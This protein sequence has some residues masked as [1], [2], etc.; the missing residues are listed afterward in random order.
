MLSEI[1]FFGIFWLI[2]LFGVANMA[3]VFCINIPF[4]KCSV[5]CGKSWRGKRIFGENKTW[6]GILAA[7]VLGFLFFIIQR[8]LFIE[9]NF[10]LRVSLFDYQVVPWFYGFFIGLGAILGDLIKSFF[11]RRANLAPGH[12]W[13][14]F[15]QIDYLIGGMIALEPFYRPDI[16]AFFL[17]ILFGF[18]LHLFVKFIGYILKISDKKI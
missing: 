16:F 7:T 12:S 2:A 18:V 13:I 14:P 17:I 10:F 1:N 5:D 11:K 8:Q 3:P 4:L 6:R 15:D 9:S